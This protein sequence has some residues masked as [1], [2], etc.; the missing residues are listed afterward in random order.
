MK[1]R[2]RPKMK[3]YPTVVIVL[4]SILVVAGSTESEAW[5]VE[6]LAQVE[7]NGKS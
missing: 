6:Q 4:L 5:K 7:S 1:L 3:P 2:L